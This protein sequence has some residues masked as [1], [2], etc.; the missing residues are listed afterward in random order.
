M[1]Q[2]ELQNLLVH[3]RELLDQ[4]TGLLEKERSSLESRNLS[5]L[6]GILQQKQSVLA[7]IEGNDQKRRQLLLKA[8]VPENQTSIAQLSAL[9]GRDSDAHLHDLLDS[10]KQRLDNCREL[11]ETN[12]IIVHRSQ[13]NT[14][15]ALDI[16]RGNENAEKLYNRH[17]SRLTASQ[18]RNLGQA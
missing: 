4:L 8:G 17:G 1:S 2:S 6:D 18:R 7:S 14:Q 12:R 13:V 5:A 16:L 10:I 15:R 9:I 11:S 3:D